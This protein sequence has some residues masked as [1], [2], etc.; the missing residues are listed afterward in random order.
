MPWGCIDSGNSA[1]IRWNLR[2]KV[3]Y[4]QWVSA[5]A[6]DNRMDIFITGPEL[7]PRQVQY[8]INVG[9]HCSESANILP[10]ARDEG[11]SRAERDVSD[12]II[13]IFAEENS[14]YHHSV[15]NI[16]DSGFTALQMFGLELFVRQCKRV[17]LAEAAIQLI[18]GGRTECSVS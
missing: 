14:A 10:L 18:Q 12:W 1:G 13:N 8:E 7:Y 11:W 15:P 9:A 3:S 16:T 5:E 2:N 17:S 4:Q 6:A